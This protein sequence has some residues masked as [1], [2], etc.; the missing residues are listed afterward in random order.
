MRL[1]GLVKLLVRARVKSGADFLK[2]CVWA[3]AD[4]ASHCGIEV[5]ASSPKGAVFCHRFW[6]SFV[7]EPMIPTCNF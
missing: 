1:T 3:E 7:S 6:G 2:V 5:G 4:F